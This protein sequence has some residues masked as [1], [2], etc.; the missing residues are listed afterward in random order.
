VSTAT[1]ILP[2]LAALGIVGG[3]IGGMVAFALV[4]RKP[5]KGAQA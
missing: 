4:W 1:S 5:W 3:P 2:A